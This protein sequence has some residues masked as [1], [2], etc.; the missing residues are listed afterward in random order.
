M[1]SPGVLQFV[2]ASPRTTYLL[3]R[4]AADSL[5]AASGCWAL[6]CCPEIFQV[7]AA[8]SRRQQIKN[9]GLSRSRPKGRSTNSKMERPWCR[10][11]ASQAPPITR[12][13]ATP[14]WELRN[15]AWEGVTALFSGREAGLAAGEGRRLG[16]GI[17]VSPASFSSF[18]T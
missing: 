18:P 10:L 1:S 8:K 17:G 3:K 5:P 16:G 14:I 12:Q 4:T 6:P 11:V 7:M 2:L 9:A 13:A 15:K